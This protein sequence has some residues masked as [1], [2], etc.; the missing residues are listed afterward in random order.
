MKYYKLTTLGASRKDIGVSPQSTECHFGDI[1]KDFIPYEG[2]IDF[3][4][5]L[6]IPKLR[7]KA[8]ATSMLDVVAIPSTFLVMSK[9]FLDFLKNFELGAYQKWDIQVH[10]RN[11]QMNDYVLFYM[12]ETKQSEY[13]D[14]EN[15]EFY[16]GSLNDYKYVGDYLSILDY[17]NYLSTREILSE[18][19][20]WLKHRKVVLDLSNTKEDMFRLVNSPNSGYFVSEQLKNAIQEK[21]FTGMVFKEIS[22][23]RNKVEVIY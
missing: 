20:L 3:E 16:I 7:N 4:F 11:E 13:V 6:P 8:R 9:Y 1:Q 21:K 17:E 18:D 12:N 15:S 23:K 19:N 14:F 2:V 10:H 22:D 5:E